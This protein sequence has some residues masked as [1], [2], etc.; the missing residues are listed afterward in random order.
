MSPVALDRALAGCL[1]TW[2]GAYLLRM[3]EGK[4]RPGMDARYTVVSTCSRG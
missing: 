2:H 4:G 3:M 1:S